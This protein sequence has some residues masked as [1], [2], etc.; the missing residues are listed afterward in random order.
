MTQSRFH[1]IKYILI[2]L[3][4]IVIVPYIGSF[5]TI[6][7]RTTAI[8]I[9]AI[10]L[11]ALPFMSVGISSLLVIAL[12]LSLEVTGSFA[13]A[14]SGF[15][16]MSAYFLLTISILG[17]IMMKV[18]IGDHVTRFILRVSKK[19]TLRASLVIFLVS[20]FMPIFLP[21]AS[22]RLKLSLPIIDEL[23]LKF[24]LESKSR[25]LLLNYMSA[26][27]LNQI[28]QIMYL[29]GGPM[30]IIAMQVIIDNGGDYLTWIGWL[31]YMFVPVFLSLCIIWLFLVFYYKPYKDKPIT[32]QTVEKETDKKTEESTNED[33][34]KNLQL[35]ISIFVLMVLVWILEP[36]LHIPLIVPPL[37]AVFIFSLPNIR[38]IRV[39]ELSTKADWNFFVFFATAL[40][41]G[42]VIQNNGTGEWLADLILEHVNLSQLNIY[43]FLIFIAITL[44][45][46]LTLITPA[47]SI[48]FIGAVF[49][50]TIQLPIP[51]TE[52]TLI[53]LFTVPSFMI[54]PVYTPILN[55]VYITGKIK[56][57]DHVVITTVY[58]II[59]I[60]MSFVFYF[61]PEL[62]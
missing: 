6:E 23:N 3:M 31:G 29:T 49:L 46:R 47:T 54:I 9:V 2:Y 12:L 24:N 17:N 61:L 57:H 41:L 42:K 7:F 20:V 40:S 25:F 58:L 43:V 60:L 13:E 59:S 30:S 62:M 52:L 48:A 56:L 32:N 26:G 50:P 55:L 45:L 10:F 27:I 16:S 11:W 53:M 39:N 28:S 8:L 34:G 5:A 19:N 4:I 51:I 22:A 35:T 44:L 1:V 36:I 33:T 38:L 18:G 14:M 21:S 37:V 15:L